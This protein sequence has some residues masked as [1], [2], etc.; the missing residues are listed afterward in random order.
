[1]QSVSTIAADLTQKLACFSIL[2]AWLVWSA[3]VHLHMM[4]LLSASN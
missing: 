2:M 4:S 1:M 3:H